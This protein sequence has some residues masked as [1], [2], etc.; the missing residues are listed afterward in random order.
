MGQDLAVGI[1]P[2]RPLIDGDSRQ[3][4]AVDLDP[5][6]VGPGEVVANGNGDELARPADLAQHPLPIAVL[7]FN[8]LGKGGEGRRNIRRLLGDDEQAVVV[9]VGGERPAEAIEDAAPGRRK[10]P[11]VDAVFVGEHQVALGLDHLQLVQ[12]RRQ[13]RQQQPLAAGDEEGAASELAASIVIARHLR[14]ASGR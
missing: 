9:A 8:Q 14:P 5:G 13:C 4:E 2:G 1:D 3:I 12:P 11:E 10:Q 7:D 6:N